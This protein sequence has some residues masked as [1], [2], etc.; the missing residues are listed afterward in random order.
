MD[1]G[2]E[3]KQREKSQEERGKNQGCRVR[4]QR[5]FTVI[6]DV[7]PIYDF[8]LE[9]AKVVEK[10]RETWQPVEK[11]FEFEGY[12][13]SHKDE[14]ISYTAYY[15]ELTGF[16][17]DKEEAFAG[18]VTKKIKGLLNENTLSDEQKPI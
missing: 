10:L 11:T 3:V 5:D 1:M 7:L 8:E 17:T 18:F 6:D 9:L 15:N 12:H 13:G 4:L 16:Y 14:K 2:K